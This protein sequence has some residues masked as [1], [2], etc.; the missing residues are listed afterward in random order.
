MATSIP[1]QKIAEL[2]DS[3]FAQHTADIKRLDFN[4]DSLYVAAQ[5][6]NLIDS[7]PSLNADQKHALI[8]KAVDEF[9]A[10]EEKEFGKELL[11]VI[12]SIKSIKGKITEL[13]K[14]EYTDP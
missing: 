12:K 3:L 7:D 14:V 13:A 9:K 8:Q 10:R 6:G 5:V 2:L 4:I 11:D 1:I